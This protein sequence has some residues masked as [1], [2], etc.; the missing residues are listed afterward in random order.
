MIPAFVEY[1]TRTPSPALVG[2]RQVPVLEFLPMTTENCTYL[3]TRICLFVSVRDVRNLSGREILPRYR[4]SREDRVPFVV[5]LLQLVF[6]SNINSAYFSSVASI[7]CVVSDLAPAWLKIND[8]PKATMPH[9][10]PLSAPRTCHSR[11]LSKR[12]KSERTT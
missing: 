1:W 3:Q 9:E 12:N 8:F 4:P 5:K 10:N 2:G 6:V 7:G 11:K